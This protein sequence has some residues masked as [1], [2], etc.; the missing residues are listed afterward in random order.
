[1]TSAEVSGKI[2]VHPNCGICIFSIISDAIRFS[3]LL[4]HCLL[5]YKAGWQKR[6]A[7][8]LNVE[9]DWWIIQI[10]VH[11]FNSLSTSTGCDNSQQSPS[12]HT[13][14]L[15]R[16]LDPR[17]SNCA[18]ENHNVEEVWISSESLRPGG[19]L[20]IPGEAPT[21]GWLLGDLKSP[22]HQPFNSLIMLSVCPSDSGTGRSSERGQI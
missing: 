10:V 16:P 12:L 13:V 4:Y 21:F 5:R 7:G 6:M 3:D 18:F 19:Q 8:F 15:V 11:Y 20:I 9:I 1:M 17:G 14:A 2:C 22:Q